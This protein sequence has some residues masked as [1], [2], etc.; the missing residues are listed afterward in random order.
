ME[1]LFEG[2]KASPITVNTLT[3]LAGNARLGEVGKVID[4]YSTLMKAERKEVDAVITSATELTAAQTKKITKALEGQIPA[5]SSVKISTTVDE[6]LLGGITVQIGD[7][8]LDLS[9]ASKIAAISR[10]M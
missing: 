6:K 1:K 4:A 10:A 3:A 9:A 8:Y 7:K 5:G 2:S